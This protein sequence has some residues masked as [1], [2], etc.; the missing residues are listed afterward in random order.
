MFRIFLDPEPL[1]LLSRR[2]ARV[3]DPVR[4]EGPA[5]GPHDVH[6]RGGGQQRGGA[7]SAQPLLD[8]RRVAAEAAE[9]GRSADRDA[10]EASPASQ[11]SFPSFVCPYYLY[12]RW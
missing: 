1:R 12:L 6:G 5:G 8:L 4:L 10:A 9:P 3:R 11:V 2:L 7:A